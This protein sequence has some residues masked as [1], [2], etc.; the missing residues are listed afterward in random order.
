MVHTGPGLKFGQV[1]LSGISTPSHLTPG[2]YSHSLRHMQWC[3]S[4][5][6]QGSSLVKSLVHGTSASP[7]SPPLSNLTPDRRC[8]LPS[9]CCDR[10]PTEAWLFL[11]PIRAQVPIIEKKAIPIAPTIPMR[12]NNS[13]I[14]LTY[15][16]YSYINVKHKNNE[17]II[18][19]KQ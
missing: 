9:A 11:S 6:N 1:R 13:K 5:T 8:A 2:L 12:I 4:Y 17:R 7:P 14:I 19:Q 3:A 10:S 18:C 15:I 16:G